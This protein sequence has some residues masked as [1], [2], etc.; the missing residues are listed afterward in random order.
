MMQVMTD[1]YGECVKEVKI[2][3]ERMEDMEKKVGINQKGT[4]SNELQLT[5][6]DTEKNAKEPESESVN[7]DKGKMEN[8]VDATNTQPTA[9]IVEPTK[10]D[11]QREEERRISK[12]DIMKEYYRAKSELERKLAP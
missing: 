6:S 10:S 1:A 11:L 5:L 7:G 12:T 9:V 2:L 3:R 4:D 8:N